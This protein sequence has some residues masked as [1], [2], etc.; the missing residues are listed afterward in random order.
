FASIGFEHDV[1]WLDIAMYH[2]ACFGSSQ[3]PR[4]LLDYLQRERER[5]WAIAADTGFQCFAFN[6][7]HG[8]ETLAVLLP[9]I[10]H[11]RNVWMMN[12]RSRARLTQKTR[13]RAGIL[14]Y[15]PVDDFEGH[16]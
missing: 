1:R 14:G 15:A 7:F 2:T 8:V 9:V 12:I 10:S 5:H 6:Q 4:S 11:P 3:R 16:L 13:P